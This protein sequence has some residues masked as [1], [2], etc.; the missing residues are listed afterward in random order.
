[1][2]PLLNFNDYLVEQAVVNALKKEINKHGYNKLEDRT[3][4]KIAVFVPK[5]D[6]ESEMEKLTSAMK[7]QGASRDTSTAG[8]NAGGS[9][10]VIKFTGGPYQK[11]N[12]IFKPDATQDLKTDE[13]E[14]LSAYCCALK[15]KNP[16]T[17][18]T[19]DEFS[20]VSI[21]SQ[22]T[23]KQLLDKAPDGWVKSSILHA[24]RLYRTFGKNNYIFCQRSN[25]KFVDNI[26]SKA[27][28]LLKKADKKISIDKWNPA[29]MW[30]V[31]PRLINMSFDHFDSIHMLNSFLY[32]Q[33]TKKMI[34]GVSLKFAKNSA[35]AEVFNYRFGQRPVQFDSFGLGKTGFTKSMYG[36]IYYNRG[37]SVVLRSFKAV[38][39]ISGEINGKYAQGGKVGHGPLKRILSECVP[40]ARITPKVEILRNF[41][42]NPNRYLDNLYNKAKALDKRLNSVKKEDFR[43]EILARGN[44]VPTYIISKSQALDFVNDLSG[45]TKKKI[46]C[47]ISKMISYA[48]S[49]TEVSSV[50][51]K[52]S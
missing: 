4:T 36:F 37:S 38:G 33:Y 39:D 9:L 17:D 12:I 19:L 23:A 3:K 26:S 41:K 28:E 5:A 2:L 45:A 25:S 30:M 11:L 40:R 10:G 6:R 29:D 50:F 13:H 7:N 47:A 24:E 51:V 22:Y 32:E 49:T 46:E 20:N 15:F 8:L 21:Q 52:V 44:A 14:S 16:K 34:V 35:K 1:M 43:K 18:F 42:A 27:L 31:N 48:A